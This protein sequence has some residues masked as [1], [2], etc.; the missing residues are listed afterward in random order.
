[1]LPDV[2]PQASLPRRL[3]DAVAVG[4]V[5]GEERL[6]FPLKVGPG[7][8][9]DTARDSE[10]PGGDQEAHGHRDLALGAVG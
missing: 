9:G 5:L 6:D 10:H 4:A 8:G 3:V 2:E 1:V 7:R